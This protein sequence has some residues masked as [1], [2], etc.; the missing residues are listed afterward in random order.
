[1]YIFKVNK[2]SH[3]IKELSSLDCN[4]KPGD[5]EIAEFEPLN[6]PYADS[7]PDHYTIFHEV[8]YWR[9]F[10]AL[11]SWFVANV[12]NAVDDCR[13]YEIDCDDLR[14]CLATLTVANEMN[15]SELLPPTQGFFWGSTTVDDYYWNAVESSIEK[16]S[17]LIYNT[18][19]NKERLFYQSSW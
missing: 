17:K 5:P 19:W 6:Q 4:P 7:A 13:L 10:N 14:D 8:A 1:M 2:T 16:I 12:Q 3:S 18:D 11:H 9:K 15:D